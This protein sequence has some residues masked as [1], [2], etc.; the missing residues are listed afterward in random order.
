MNPVAP[1]P[2]SVLNDFNHSFSGTKEYFKR[3]LQYWITEYKVDGY[4]MDLTKGFTQNS[5]TESTAGN[6]DQSRIDNLSAY[7]DAAKAVKSDVMF[8]LEHFCN[9]DEET[10]LAN[11][12]MYLWRNVNSAFSQSAEGFSLVTVA[13]LGAVAM[14]WLFAISAAVVPAY[15]KASESRYFTVVRSSAEAALDYTVN[16]L[17]QALAAEQVSAIDDTTVDDKV[18]AVTSVD[19]KSVV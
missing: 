7:Y 2:Y 6:Y 17:N 5:S 13:A 12:G 18:Y 8:I 9:N 14:L 1:H 4:R 16:E 19:R 11:K 3:V 10:A 15:Q